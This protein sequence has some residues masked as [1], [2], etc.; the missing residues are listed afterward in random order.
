LARRPTIALGARESASAE[1]R[2]EALWREILDSHTAPGFERLP[3]L[4]YPSG[5]LGMTQE[6]D[7]TPIEPLGIPTLSSDEIDA[8]VAFLEALTDER[9]VYQ[10]APFDHP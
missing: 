3:R 9:V 6:L 5:E 8:I 7:G 2:F 1:A 4:R 10:R